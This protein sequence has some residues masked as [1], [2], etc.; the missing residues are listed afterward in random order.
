MRSNNS[1]FTLVEIMIVVMITG[2]LATLSVPH[3]LK[4]RENTHRAVCQSNLRHIG[5]EAEIYRFENPDNESIS[6]GDIAGQFKNGVIPSC[7]AGGN[8]RID[9]DLDPFVFCDHGDGHEL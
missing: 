2:L 3:Y 9:V 7:P 1:G 8:Y 4:S 5:S 6:L